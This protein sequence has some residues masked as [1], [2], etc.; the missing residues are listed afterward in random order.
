MI[1]NVILCKSTYFKANRIRNVSSNRV[2]GNEVYG[3]D[4]E[5][6]G[7]N[8]LSNDFRLCNSDEWRSKNHGG[9]VVIHGYGVGDMVFLGHVINGAGIHVDPIKIEAAKNWKAPRTL[10]EVRSFLGLAGY[11]RRFIENFSKIAM[12][13]T[14]L[15]QKYLPD[16]P[17]D[18]MMYYDASG[19]RLGCVLMQSGMVIAYASMQ[20]KINEK[21]YTNHDLELGE[22]IFSQKELNMR[23]R[24]WI[25]LFSHYDCEIHYHPGKANVVVDALSK[26][27]QVK[28]K[29]VREMNMTLH[30]S[31]KDRILAAEK[32]ASNESAGLQKGDVR[33][34]IKD[35][36][37]KSKYYVY[38]GADNMYYD[39]KDSFWWPGMKKDLAVFVS[40]VR[41]GKKGK[42]A[43]R[44]VGPF[45]IIEKVGPVAY[46]LD[47]LEELDGVHDT[48]YVSNLK[49]CLAEPTQQVLLDEIRVD[50]KLNFIEE[51]VEIMEREFKKLKWSR[52]TI[53]KVR[54]NSKRGP[55]IMWERKDQM[56]LKYPHLF[57]AYNS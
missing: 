7:V 8:P 40:V 14:V 11:Y 9:R 1:T 13:L 27:E 28:T 45:E 47:L 31:I 34:L 42:L 46:G 5:G 18:F 37:H 22:H 38:P 16:G 20:L 17:E 32:E 3:V 23:Q 50:G 44:F 24:R 39:L 2:F 4:S 54:W 51:L 21:N 43:P 36:A 15:T 57:S 56:K 19:L 26:K 29:R 25:E 52:I 30:S 41:Y 55:I 48:F 53:V 6:L 33:T 12:P 10:S 49:K 35:E